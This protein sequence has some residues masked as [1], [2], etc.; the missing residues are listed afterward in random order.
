MP[1]DH[2][3]HEKPSCGIDD[4]ITIACSDLTDSFDTIAGNGDGAL[5]RCGPAAI[6]YPGIV[7][8]G[9]RHRPLLTVFLMAGSYG[10]F[11][12]DL[13]QMTQKNRHSAQRRVGIA[14][15]KGG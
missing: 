14:K 5:K 11:L 7:D 2:A 9:P 1:F 13:R 10:R 4:A 8:D 15:T 6:E 3:R 12:C